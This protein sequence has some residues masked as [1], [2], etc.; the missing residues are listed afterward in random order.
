MNPLAGMQTVDAPVDA[1]LDEAIDALQ[2]RA[3][4]LGLSVRDAIFCCEHSHADA[5]VKGALQLRSELLSH[6]AWLFTR[7]LSRLLCVRGQYKAGEPLQPLLVE[8][9]GYSRFLAEQIQSELE[10]AGRILHSIPA[11]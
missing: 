5:S 9:L 11:E 2:G 3:L 7:S 4:S 6:T 1:V 8:M 10:E